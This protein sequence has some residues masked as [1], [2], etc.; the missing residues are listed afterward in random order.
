[1][2]KINNASNIIK[3][4]ADNFNDDSIAA[5]TAL[6]V[7]LDGS[8]K[9]RDA[10]G[11]IRP[12]PPPQ[13]PTAPREFSHAAG[14]LNHTDPGRL[15]PGLL[16]AFSGDIG[17]S[18]FPTHHFAKAWLLQLSAISG[19]LNATAS[20]PSTL[21]A[22]PV[23]TG[24][25]VFQLSPGLDGAACM[26]LHAT[27]ESEAAVEYVET[28]A[29]AYVHYAYEESRNGAVFIANEGSP[30]V[31]EDFGELYITLVSYPT[32][33]VGRS[34]RRVYICQGM[35]SI[36]YE[37]DLGGI[38]I[39]GKDSGDPARL[40]APA[41]VRRFT[42]RFNGL[43][44]SPD[45]VT[46]A[47]P[48][49]ADFALSPKIG[50]VLTDA[51]LNEFLRLRMLASDPHVFIFG[52]RD[53]TTGDAVFADQ[54]SVTTVSTMSS[55]DLVA[56]SDFNTAA[57]SFFQTFGVDGSAV[58]LTGNPPS[59][60][61][62]VLEMIGFST[63]ELTSSID[64]T[65]LV[66]KFPVGSIAQT[67]GSV[68]TE[69]FDFYNNKIVSTIRF[70]A[71]I[72]GTDMS[73]SVT[74][75]NIWSKEA[76]AL[77]PV[78]PIC[79]RTLP[80]F[81]PG[82]SSSAKTEAVISLDPTS[83]GMPTNISAIPSIAAKK[84]FY[85]FDGTTN[86]KPITNFYV[87]STQLIAG[88][89]TPSTVAAPAFGAL[90]FWDPILGADSTPPDIITISRPSGFRILEASSLVGE[91]GE[92]ITFTRQTAPTLGTNLRDSLYTG[93]S[94]SDIS[95]IEEE[96]RIVFNDPATDEA[97]AVWSQ[98]FVGT[99][100]EWGRRAYRYA[101]MIE[102][103]ARGDPASYPS[104]VSNIPET[105]SLASANLW[106]GLKRIL[107]FGVDIGYAPT[108]GSISTLKVVYPNSSEFTG[109]TFD[110]HVRQWSHLKYDRGSA[111]SI[112][113]FHSPWG[114]FTS[115]VDGEMYRWGVVVD[116]TG[117]PL[118]PGG[119]LSNYTT[120]PDTADGKKVLC[121]AE[122][123]T[124]VRDPTAAAVNDIRVPTDGFGFFANHHHAFGYLI[125]A[126]FVAL[127]YGGDRTTAVQGG[128]LK[129]VKNDIYDFLAKPLPPAVDLSDASAA[130]QEPF[131]LLQM[132]L[133]VVGGA[134]GQSVIAPSSLVDAVERVFPPFRYFDVYHS[135]SWSG[136]MIPGESQ[137]TKAHRFGESIVCY[138]AI[139][140]FLKQVA[141]SFPSSELF[142][143][144]YV[145]LLKDGNSV[146]H[147]QGVMLS[148]IAGVESMIQPSVD[149]LNTA[150]IEASALSSHSDT[151]YSYSG[152]RGFPTV[153]SRSFVSQ[154]FGEV[155]TT[156]FS[157][158]CGRITDTT[159]RQKSFSSLAAVFPFIAADT[160]S[161]ISEATY[162]LSTYAW[163]RTMRTSSFN[164]LL[165]PTSTLGTW[166][167]KWLSNH[168]SGAETSDTDPSE[169]T[170]ATLRLLA[171]IIRH[172]PSVTGG[173]GIAFPNSVE[174]YAPTSSRFDVTSWFK[175][176]GSS[177]VLG[178]SDSVPP[179]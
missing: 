114:G 29:G 7:R 147:L 51:A 14:S 149:M 21:Y 15:A 18:A 53:E 110:E 57:T 4:V 27:V 30:W 100:A 88:G 99:M 64:V 6:F 151:L 61:A 93:L 76:P 83:Y 26:M 25:W 108:S 138:H 84:L 171:L 13:W 44:S 94:A 71:V 111:T 96:L 65:L 75:S 165:S 46:V 82:A 107:T 35:A 163:A 28:D 50:T 154:V 80:T 135:F 153:A 48:S 146:N 97:K 19:P 105:A 69:G 32:T 143:L 116:S 113:S 129:T 42:R 102:M 127:R 52:Y 47:T 55:A 156:A 67:G 85:N 164:H 179:P 23:V 87:P 112:A 17:K 144:R 160:I 136:G 11:Y 45:G 90:R 123:H 58:S 177:V 121:V 89:A 10:S 72:G 169:T 9:Y 24:P 131:P 159:P 95:E 126:A 142:N 37:G 60:F 16:P 137:Q 128:V 34:V 145:N 101:R 78:V 73:L 5:G 63:H 20:H 132:I 162:L 54:T 106:V 2:S 38:S 119:S 166:L 68:V 175:A 130:T 31:V 109:R 59:I 39:A 12:L 49:N 40:V 81:T 176:I 33:T 77:K 104:G 115:H 79:S 74:T 148:E 152:T 173:A 155:V 161:P 103:L 1:M 43:S 41:A 178:S 118:Y 66:S 170:Q 22:G 167:D 62:S 120:E 117:V 168:T 172:R 98:P 150:A 124:L 91:A 140:R 134:A 86:S 174:G 8:L 70:T 141:D 157:S 92:G 158:G 139:W 125:H 3:I 56:V 36:G 122:M 133:D